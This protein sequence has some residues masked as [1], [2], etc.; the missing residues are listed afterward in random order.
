MNFSLQLQM[1]QLHNS[2]Y[3]SKWYEESPR[4]RKD[5]LTMMI[6][7]TKRINLNYRMFI[8]YNYVCL[9]SVIHFLLQSISKSKTK[10][11][12]W[13]HYPEIILRFYLLE[14]NFSSIMCMH[15]KYMEVCSYFREK[16]PQ[17]V[18]NPGSNDVLL[19]E[20]FQKQIKPP[21]SVH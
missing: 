4:V 18:N 15:A 13:T 14:Y 1:E 2:A 11:L 8:T 7:T 16:P 9:G 19:V 12:V 6:I 21:L 17:K 5:L 20:G 3:A 10:T